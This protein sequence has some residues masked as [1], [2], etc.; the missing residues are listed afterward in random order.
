MDLLLNFKE[1]AMEHFDLL[2]K[3]LDGVIQQKL[4]KLTK[5][6]SI[7]QMREI[8]RFLREARRLRK[9]LVSF[10]ALDES[11]IPDYA[12]MDDQGNETDYI[13]ILV[14]GC[15]LINGLCSVIDYKK[16]K[17]TKSDWLLD[18]ANDYMS[19]LRHVF[20]KRIPSLVGSMQGRDEN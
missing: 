19:A 13:E 3:Q 10:S 14:D 11:E 20:G 1:L 8:N 12:I 4:S 6:S 7:K 2:V 15:T 5:I 16:I 18:D 17:E 9:T